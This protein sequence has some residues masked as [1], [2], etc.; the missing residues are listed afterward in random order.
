MLLRPKT[1]LKD[2]VAELTPGTR[3]AGELPPGERIPIGQTAPDVN[4]DEILASL[5]DD[6]RTYLQL[7][8]SEGGQALGGNSRAL[9]NTI[10]RFE[11]TARY[12]AQIAEQLASAG[13]RTSAA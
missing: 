3:A 7:L 6:T 12:T 9:A 4:L 1:G 11:P 13:A 8:L 10:R 2:M 5:D